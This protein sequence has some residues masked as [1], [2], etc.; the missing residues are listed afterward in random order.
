MERI[1][2]CLDMLTRRRGYIAV[3]MVLIKILGEEISEI[4]AKASNIIVNS[5]EVKPKVEILKTM[6]GI[7]NWLFN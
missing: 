6:L 2:R 4:Y 1:I 3:L 7:G 5:S